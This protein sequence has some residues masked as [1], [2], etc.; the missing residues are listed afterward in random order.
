MWSGRGSNGLQ[1]GMTIVVPEELVSTF[2][3]GLLGVADV[4]GG[5]TDEQV[6]VISAVSNHLW[7]QDVSLLNGIAPGPL[8]EALNDDEL[9]RRFVQLAIIVMFCRHPHAEEQVAHLDLYASALGIHGDE[10]DAVSSWIS[11]TT[12]LASIDFIRSYGH[13]L[14]ALSD[15]VAALVGGGDVLPEVEALRLLPEGTLGW[16]FLGFYERNGFHL[17]GPETPTPAYYISHDMNHVI[18]G[19]E[20]TGPGEISL[21]AFKLAMSDTDANWMAFMTN[22]LIHEAGLL[23]HGST[24]QFIPYGGDIYPD[25]NGQGALHLPGA[26]SMLGEA[27]ERGSA[28]HGDFSQIDHLG[29]AHRPLEEIR[30]E[31]GV[32]PRSDGIDGGLGTGLGSNGR[33]R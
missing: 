1:L 21:G 2:V 6:S 19:Y 25:A 3:S 4:E 17:P 18:A 27:F 11:E 13:Y 32:V 22:L 28:V 14:P 26:A 31:Y 24:T 8:A 5:P 16:A 12:E 30:A 9:R 7:H 33:Q 23:K 15:Q 10:L 20:P 29:I